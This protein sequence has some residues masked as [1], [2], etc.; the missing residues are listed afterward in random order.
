LADVARQYADRHRGAKWQV[1]ISDDDGQI[2]DVITTRRRPTQRIS[3]LVNAAQPVC[4]FPGCRMPAE[5]CD[6][7]H[8]LPAALGGATSV[9][10]GGPKCRHDHILKDKGWKHQRSH[11]TD[12]WTSPHG[13]IYRTEKPP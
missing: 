1:T 7:D 13:H 8:H 9:R 2:V 4:A 5:D 12:Y 10:N 11:G 3:R 6:F